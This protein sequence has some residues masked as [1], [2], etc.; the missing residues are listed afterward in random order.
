MREKPF[1]RSAYNYDPDDASD[2]AGL[3]CGEPTLTQQNF[4]EEVDIN[5]LIRRFHLSGEMPEDVRPITYGDFSDVYDFHTAANAI[6]EAR[7]S[8]E[9]MPAELRRRFE[10][11]PA[12][13]VAFCSDAENL[14]EMRKMGLAVAA[15]V[16]PP[17]EPPLPDPT[18]TGGA[19]A[20]VDPAPSAPAA[21]SA[22][23]A[24]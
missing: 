8:F 22:P 20:P 13:F 9:S 24:A 10:N 1:V 23:A 15:R 12:K 11:D 17:G 21:G 6:A 16:P 2:I 3:S 18:R 4:A 7:E 14:D 5:T 19:P